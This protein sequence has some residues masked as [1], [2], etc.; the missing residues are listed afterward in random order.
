MKGTSMSEIN[1]YCDETCHLPND[2]IDL[3]VI[4][5]IS[6]PKEKVKDINRQIR[7]IKEKH[8]VYKFAEIKWVRVSNS[9]FDMYK[10][11]I[12]LFFDN[13]FLNFRAVVA[14]NKSK[15]DYRRFH[16]THDDWY[17]RIYYLML[18]GMIDI[19]D[20]YHVYVDIKDTK[21]AEKINTLRDV[22]NNAAGYFYEETVES[23]QLLKSDQVQ[24]MQLTDLLI[25]AVAYANRGLNSSKAKIDLVSYIE[26]RSNRMLK[27]TSPKNEVKFNV[28]Q[29]LPRE[30]H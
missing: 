15:L 5:G 25:G 9:Q 27:R 17:Q 11:L 2:G 23:I 26:E 28:F 18:R 21:G 29:W 12:D 16:L 24:L 10:E 22:L 14:H 19:N 3:M 4:G 7:N 8:N 1:I 6:C 13:S 30:V 20:S